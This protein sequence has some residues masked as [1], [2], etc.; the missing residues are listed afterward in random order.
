MWWE[1]K[2]L[3]TIFLH[4]VICVWS[5]EQSL[6][7]SPWPSDGRLV[8][9]ILFSGLWRQKQNFV[10][11][12]WL[13]FYVSFPFFFFVKFGSEVYCSYVN[14]KDIEKQDRTLTTKFWPHNWYIHLNDFTMNPDNELLLRSVIYKCWKNNCRLKPRFKQSSI[15]SLLLTQ[16]R[17]SYTCYWQWRCR[18][19]RRKVW[20]IC[21]WVVFKH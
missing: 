11:R 3:I 8:T 9:T 20:E 13:C 16:A 19:S 2:N 5:L 7:D 6:P 17:M 14:W 15:F 12:D 4:G 1:K 21:M 18:F 10:V